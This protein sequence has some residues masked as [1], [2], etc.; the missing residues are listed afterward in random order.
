MKAIIL[1]AGKGSRISEAIGGVPKSVLEIN[2]EPIIRNTVKLLLS[3]GI[4][5]IVCVGYMHKKIQEVL[6][7]LKVTYCFNPFYDI[8][9]NIVSLWFAREYLN[10][11]DIILMS[12]DIVFQKEIILKLC[13]ANDDLIM[14][15]DK[16]RCNDGDYFFVL[17][18]NNSI[19]EY[20]P[21][22]PVEVR[23]CEYVGIS[24]ISKRVVKD[25][26]YRLD[27]IIEEGKSS[28]YFESVFFTYIKDIRYKLTTIDISGLLWREI[29]FYED[30]EKA[31]L[32]S[33]SS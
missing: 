26:A 13:Y 11:D 29:D 15:A 22:I 6:K 12:A 28:A 10:N 2:G 8:T 32:Q 24:K 19:I 27:N 9:N 18:K 14:V 16:S 3:L 23:N 21:E 17:D 7:E 4:E 20:G 25:F 33:I 31:V 5:T 1:A 30:Y